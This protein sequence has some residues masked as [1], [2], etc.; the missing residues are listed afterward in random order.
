MC[1]SIQLLDCPV[2]C[3]IFGFHGDEASGRSLLGCDTV[4]PCGRTP[5]FRRPF[6]LKPR[7]PRPEYCTDLLIPCGHHATDLLTPCGRHTT[8]D[9]PS[10]GQQDNCGDSKV[11]RDIVG[12]E[13]PVFKFCIVKEF[14]K[15]LKYYS[16]LF[17][18]DMAMAENR[19]N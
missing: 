19:T 17:L 4:L 15:C 6:Y 14:W 16:V 18:E 12:F 1:T 3:E 11:T 7:R 2:T 9:P 5:T 10:F 8:G 13:C